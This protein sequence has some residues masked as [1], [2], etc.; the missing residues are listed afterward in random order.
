M[1]L[2]K[3]TGCAPTPLAHYLKALGI[4][5]LVAEQKDPEARGF[6]KDDVFCLAT[7]LSEDELEHFFLDDY[8]P[9]PVVAPWN[10]GSGFG[11]WASKKGRVRSEPAI[12]AL[13]GSQAPRFAAYREAI[14]LSKEVFGALPQKPKDEE[15]G[16]HIGHFRARLSESSTS[17]DWLDAAIVLGTDK[18]L[19]PALLGSGGNDGSI[20][21]TRN[22]MQRLMELFDADGQACGAARELLKAALW[23]GATAALGDLSLGQ[24]FPSE[25]P[26]NPWDFALM[27]EGAVVLQVSAVRR[28][29][30]S[31]LAQAA[32]PFAVQGRAAGYASASEADGANGRGEQWMPLWSA[33]TRFAEVKA[34]FA[35]GRLKSGK[36][37][38]RRPVEAALAIRRLGTA[39]GVE[40]FQRYGFIVRNGL[41]ILSVPIG[42]WQ[43]DESPELRPLLDVSDWCERLLWKTGEESAALQKLARDLNTA[44]LD[45]CRDSRTAARWQNLLILLGEA[46]DAIVCRP[47]LM[48]AMPPLPR[49]SLKWLKRSRTGDPEFRLALALA[50]QTGVTAK[51]EVPEIRAHCLPITRFNK[52]D[53]TNAPRV[54]WSPAASLTDNLLAVLQRRLMESQ[55]AGLDHLAFQSNFS[56]SIADLEAFLDGEVNDRR[57]AA[58]ARGLMAVDFSKA[59]STSSPHGQRKPTSLHALF[60]LCLLRHPLQDDSDLP[61]SPA[62]LRLLESG[63]LSAAGRRAVQHL[64]AHGLRVN[65]SVFIAYRKAR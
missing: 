41:S 53:E 57:I 38:V 14:A 33:P 44:C 49:L 27:L 18:P 16:L 59:T 45:V 23:R 29:E 37:T 11:F 17:L 10:G 65:F 54:V 34:L 22:F 4:L 12:L 20:D 31:E 42:R 21:F 9:T 48:A 13:E 55:R 19:F 15:K 7:K 8:A 63:Q 40:S 61:A 3:L 64:G 58:L 39:R 32:A 60:R 62:V 35:E 26:M 52:F 28:L 56:A 24:F 47:R 46:E 25:A 50:S 36:K 1:H 43:V 2:H 5:R 30:G 6:W 51:D